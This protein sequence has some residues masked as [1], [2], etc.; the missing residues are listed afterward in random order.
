MVDR[1]EIDTPTLIIADRG[2]ESYNNM[3]HIKEKGW[4]YLIRIKDYS[5]HSSGI[6]HGLKLPDTDEF[7]TEIDLNLTKKR[8]NEVKELLK[9]KNRYRCISTDKTF[10]YLPRKSKKSDHIVMYNLPFRIVRFKITDDTYEVVVTNLD[11]TDFPAQVLKE[12]YFMRWGIE[13]S[14][15][16]LKYTVGL[17][18][19]HSKKVEYI[20]QEIFA[21]LIMYNFLYNTNST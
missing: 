8:S 3:S 10:D 21:R 9:D 15:R 6:L 5:T 20:L 13:T 18:H 1:S 12:L 2:Y 14:F 19:F 4:K 11:N 17:L 16:D 7:D